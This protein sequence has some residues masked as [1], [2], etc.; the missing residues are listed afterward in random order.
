MIDCWKDKTKG[1]DIPMVSYQFTIFK[2]LGN[3][4]QI[5]PFLEVILSNNQKERNIKDVKI[6][7]TYPHIGHTIFVHTKEVYGPLKNIN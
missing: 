1:Y 2:Y 7:I 6:T 3:L 5:M 4:R